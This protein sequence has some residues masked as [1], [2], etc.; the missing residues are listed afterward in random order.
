V[1]SLYPT[2]QFYD[3][4]PVGTPTVREWPQYAP[5]PNLQDFFGFL[6]CDIEPTRYLH[7]PVIVE[8]KNG[9]LIAD[10]TKKV[11]ITIASPELHAALSQGY[12]VTRVYKMMEFES[13]TELFKDYFRDFIKNKLEASGMPGWVQTEENWQEFETYHREQLGIELKRCDMVKNS[14]RKTAAKLMCNSLWGKFAETASPIQFEQFDVAGEQGKLMALLSKWGDGKIQVVYHRRS[15]DNMRLN[16]AYKNTETEWLPPNR[17]ARINLAVAAF[18]T[19]HARMRLWTELNKLGDRVLYHDTDSIIYERSATGYNIPDGRYL[20][21]WEDECVE[22]GV[23]RKM[24]K[25]ASIGPKCYSYVL[26]DGKSTCKV[27]G[28]SLDSANSAVVNFDAMKQLIKKELPQ[29]ETENLLFKYDKGSGRRAGGMYT[30][31]LHKIV[32]VTYSKGIIDP[33]TTIVYPKGSVEIGRADLA[34]CQLWT[35]AD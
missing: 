23:K 12:K 5:V 3:P 1:Q 32:R 19:S 27:K 25:F 17:R 14:S 4:L 30:G 28:V 29:L 2:V 21:E 7:H 6:E 8:I 33:V 13:S 24:V 10:L 20:G 34:G 35:S 18:I 22:N 16:V 15:P 26:D 31:I 9:L 11:K